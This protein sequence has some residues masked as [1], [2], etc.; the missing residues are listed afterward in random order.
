MDG[1]N[2]SAT[3]RVRKGLASVA[4]GRPVSAVAGLVQLI[5]L[6]RLLP[7][8][9]YAA[10]V[11]VWAG[12]EIVVLASN[13]GL[14]HAA[15]RY[16]HADDAYGGRLAIHGPVRT[17][18]ALRA[19]SLP[20]GIVLFEAF[21]PVS[22]FL[23]ADHQTQ[24]VLSWA[25][26][27]L[28]LT[29]GLARYCE[30]I[31]ESLLLQWRAQFSTSLRAALKPIGLG[32]CLVLGWDLNLDRVLAIEVFS[33]GV[34]MLTGL[35]GLVSTMRRGKIQVR[36][37]SLA[38]PLTFRRAVR[39]VLPAFLAQL[40]GLCYGPDILKLILGYGPDTTAL[41]AFGFAFS[42]AA[43]LQRYLPV[44]ILNGIFRPL[45][46]DSVDQE[47]TPQLLSRL[48]AVTNKL[49]W[50]VIALPLVALAPIA[51]QVT[52]FL[53]K[54]NYANA[55]DVLLIL[56]A[57]LIFAAAHGVLSL[58]CLALENSRAPLVATVGAASTLPASVLLAR[59]FGSHGLA[60][61]WG[62]SE[63]VWVLVCCLALMRGSHDQISVT[64][65]ALLKIPTI[66]FCMAFTCKA[67]ALV[68]PLL[69]WP[70]SVSAPILLLYFFWKFRVFEPAEISW[71]ASV[72][73]NRL[74]SVLRKAAG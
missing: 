53:S 70:M 25:F 67:L 5:L 27:G 28:V 66:T 39:F 50:F 10:Y 40:L 57:S 11:A 14:M 31:F 69:A 4:I 35:W 26:G 72:S 43:M 34:G 60:V 24:K 48:V 32:V 58:Y 33:C 73:P 15:Y 13:L 1:A 41:A 7:P 6:S 44:N 20:L 46:V 54:G 71:F 37:N 49:N 2:S 65:S 51:T 19:C 18:L 64:W 36:K 16:V 62:L 8:V 12:V 38:G 42:M 59:Y 56:I 23:G 17:L 30:I 68:A 9:D 47:A 63:A 55:G 29:E 21:W 61:G 74:R 3:T 22:A 52:S 45:F